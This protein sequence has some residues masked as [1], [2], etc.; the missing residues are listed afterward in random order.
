[1]VKKHR[2]NLNN[3]YSHHLTHLVPFGA[4]NVECCVDTRQHN[5]KAIKKQPLI[6][7]LKKL[8]LPTEL[9]LDSFMHT[10][11]FKAPW[12]RWIGHCVQ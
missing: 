7:I 5:Y 9:S 12:L 10:V 2:I 1:M 4:L 6:L 11:G 3:Y 8:K